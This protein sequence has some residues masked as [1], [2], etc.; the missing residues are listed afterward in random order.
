MPRSR[1][2]SLRPV[3]SEKVE[4]TSSN[5]GL[6]NATDL[7]VNLA[8]GTK[9]PV[10]IDDVDIGSTIKSIFFELNIAADTITSAKVVHWAIRK[11]PF[12]TAIGNPSVYD[13]SAKRFTLHRGMEMLPKDVSTVFKRVFV[14]R[15]P[16]RLRRI[17]DGDKLVIT[18]RTSS[19]ETVN[20]C[21]FAIYRFFS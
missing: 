3:K 7:S 12:G 15:I 4:I 5:L 20:I 1:A 13:G 2:L 19:S 11:L 16:P 17:G 10:G 21:F 9:D 14:V 18:F 8:E 6:N